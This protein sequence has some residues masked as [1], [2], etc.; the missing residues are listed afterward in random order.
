MHSQLA[1]F[2]RDTP[3][4]REAADILG[5]CVH[6]GFCNATCPTY[7]LLG[8]ELDG[9]R[10]RIYLIKGALEGR[11]VTEKTRLHLDRCLTCL[12]CETTCPSGVKYGHLLDI[13]RK[14]VAEQVPRRAFDAAKRGALRGF[15]LRRWL[16]TPATK[17][18]RLLRPLLPEVLAEKLPPGT[19]AKAVQPLVGA[20]PRDMIMLAG[21][22][23]PALAPNI[24]AATTRVLGRLGIRVR[25]IA[26]AGCCG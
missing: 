13:G 26:R 6:C 2:I 19:G 15:L 11:P 24:N 3:E 8:D 1:D 23:Q 25:E 21:C 14:V 17:V 9:P 7:Q 5:K 20:Q 18:G 12:S 22:V 16:F 10:G 4:G